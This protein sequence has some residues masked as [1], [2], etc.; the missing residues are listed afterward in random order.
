MSVSAKLNRIINSASG[1][2]RPLKRARSAAGKIV[3]LAKRRRLNGDGPRGGVSKLVRRIAAATVVQTDGLQESQ[4]VNTGY[5]HTAYG[6]TAPAKVPVVNVS[7]ASPFN[8]VQLSVLSATS[9]EKIYLKKISSEVTFY[10]QSNLT[11]RLDITHWVCRKS[12][13]V[14]SYPTVTALWNADAGTSQSN[15]RWINYR[16]SNTARRYLKF[17]KI[18]TYV[19][20]PG[21]SKTFR[22]GMKYKIPRRISGFVEGDQGLILVKGISRGFTVKFHAPPI[23]NTNGDVY[24][25]GYTVPYLIRNYASWYIPGESHPTTKY[26]DLSPVPGALTPNDIVP[27]SVKQPVY[28]P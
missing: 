24:F 21:A 11:L 28:A 4:I 8:L 6:A 22:A 5:A 14:A 3:R 9:D 12:V 1:G 25:G 23:Q 26:L 17:T 27:W 16:T 19:L 20:Q 18:H 15:E 13:D 10:N 7:C 2:K